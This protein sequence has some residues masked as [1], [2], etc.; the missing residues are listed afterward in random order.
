MERLMFGAW[1]RKTRAAKNLSLTELA[2]K[3]GVSKTRI[4]GVEQEHGDVSIG[5]ADKLA[6]A[7]GT[8][9]WKVVQQ[10]PESF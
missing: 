9:L 5:V 10:F 8:P 1:V 4:W 3:S 2:E 6:T 7:L